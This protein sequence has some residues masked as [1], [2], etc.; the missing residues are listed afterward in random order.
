MRSRMYGKR[1]FAETINLRWSRTDFSQMARA[2][3]VAR[4]RNAID[5][6]NTADLE[7]SASRISAQVIFGRTQEATLAKLP[8]KVKFRPHC[9]QECLHTTALFPKSTL[10]LRASTMDVYRTS[11]SLC[12]KRRAVRAGSTRKSQKVLVAY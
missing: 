9:F 4:Q 10:S 6:R 11:Y 1:V 5:G 12:V 3:A 7:K 2:N 8:R